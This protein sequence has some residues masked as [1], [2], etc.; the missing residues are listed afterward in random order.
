MKSRTFTD[1]NIIAN[2]ESKIETDK[3]Y[4]TNVNNLIFFLNIGFSFASHFPLGESRKEFS[5]NAVLLIK[6]NASGIK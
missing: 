4:Q 2:K 5:K 1:E 6:R 3:S